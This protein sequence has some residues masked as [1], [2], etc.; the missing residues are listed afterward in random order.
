VR[1]RFSIIGFTE[2]ELGFIVAILL[3]AAMSSHRVAIAKPA[4]RPTPA[5]SR[6]D[7]ENLKRQYSQLALSNAEEIQKNLALQRAL[8]KQSNL[9]SR[10]KPSCKERNIAQGFVGEVEVAGIDQF[11]L[12]G[13]TFDMDGLVQHFS[14]EL[15]QAQGAGCVQTIRVTPGANISTR[16]Y[17]RARNALGQRF[18]PSDSAAN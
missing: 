3:F 13:K 9:R 15:K 12:K 16:D 18:Y 5:V 1:D 2:A 4:P 14:T 11:Q 17:V 10:Q 6:K 7:F 8:D